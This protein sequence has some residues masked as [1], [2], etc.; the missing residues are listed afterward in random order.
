MKASHLKCRQRRKSVGRDDAPS[1]EQ[2][3]H[4]LRPRNRRGTET[5]LRVFSKQEPLTRIFIGNANGVIKWRVYA[6]FEVP[7]CSPPVVV[8][9]AM[10][11]AATLFTISPVLTTSAA[12]GY[13]PRASRSSLGL[14]IVSAH[15]VYKQLTEN[16]H[17]INKY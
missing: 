7:H 13:E 17:K 2:S 12:L 1:A 3:G 11:R 6:R 14:A 5:T 16:S 10:L 15:F 4:K 9:S 8:L